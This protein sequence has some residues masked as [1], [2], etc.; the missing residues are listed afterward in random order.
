VGGVVPDEGTPNDD[1]RLDELVAARVADIS[2][3]LRTRLILVLGPTRRL[4]RDA[5]LTSAQ[6]SE[7]KTVFHYGNEL[8]DIVTD[9]AQITLIPSMTRIPTMRQCSSVENCG[10]EWPPVTSRSPSG[11]GAADR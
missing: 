10:T 5:N 6:R 8:L 7:L 11:S 4:L 2:Q 1:G 9:M 3:E